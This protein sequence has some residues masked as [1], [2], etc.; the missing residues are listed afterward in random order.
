MTWTACLGFWKNIKKYNKDANL[1]N[2][3][4]LMIFK[5]SLPEG[6]RLSGDKLSGDKVP[7]YLSLDDQLSSFSELYSAKILESCIIAMGL[8]YGLG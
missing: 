8:A 1:R 2:Q 6:Y 3:F 4:S 5:T 7:I